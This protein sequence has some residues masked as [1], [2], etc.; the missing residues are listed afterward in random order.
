M[1]K[2]RSVSLSLSSELTTITAGDLNSL[3]GPC[4]DGLHKHAP[5]DWLK[6]SSPQNPLLA[7]PILTCCTERLAQ[8]V[9]VNLSPRIILKHCRPA[10]AQHSYCGDGT[11]NQTEFQGH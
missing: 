5:T 2:L 4:P 10:C 8:V 9:E 7:L 1:L 11:A 3:L 6:P